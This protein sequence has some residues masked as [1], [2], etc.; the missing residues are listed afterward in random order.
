MPVDGAETVFV[1]LLVDP[2][3]VVLGAEPGGGAWVVPGQSLA[4]ILI[5]YHEV[6]FADWW[7]DLVARAAGQRHQSVAR[8]TQPDGRTSPVMVSLSSVSGGQA[9]LLTCLPPGSR[10]IA[11]LHAL[12]STSVA[13]SRLDLDGVLLTVREKVCALL[14]AECFYI[15]LYDREVGL[16]QLRE[17]VDDHQYLGGTSIVQS[18]QEGLVGWVLNNR[19]RLHVGD[20][21]RDPLPAPMVVHGSTPRALLLVP[22][23]AH[24]E[25][26]GALSVQSY[27]PDI[28]TEEDLWFLDAIAAQTA[29]AVHNAYLYDQTISRLAALASLQNTVLSLASTFDQEN[30]VA[31]VE[32]AVL[33]LLGPDEV[34]VYL[35]APLTGELCFAAG[36]TPQGRTGAREDPLLDSLVALIDEQGEPLLLADAQEG[37]AIVGDFDWPPAAL[38]G[39]PIRR[40]GQRC[41]VLLLLYREARCFRQDERHILSLLASQTAI[42]LENAR[43]H[44]D[45]VHRF[46]EVSA[47]Y[48]LAQ[49]VTG[50]LDG[51]DILQLVV[52]TMRDIF[53]CRACVLALLDEESQEIVI[54]AAAG[55]KEHWKA[56]ARFRVGE[57]VAGSVVATGRSIYVPD[58][59][60]DPN[61]LIFDPEVHSL[62]AVPVMFK[63]RVVGSLNLDSAVPN[64]FSPEH[65]RILTIAAAQVAAA[66][67]NARLY[68]AEL[69]RARKLAEAN[70]Q[71]EHYEK[72]R[73]ELIQNLAHELN[74]PLTYIKGYAGLLQAGEL[75]PVLPE[76]AEALSVV[77]EK[78]DV[79][80]QVVHDVVML[81]Q[82]SPDTLDLEP[83]EINVLARQALA[84][85]RL[86][87][88]AG[89]LRFELD[90]LPGECWVLG[91]R[92]RLNQV[93]DNLLSNAIKFTPEGG[94][95]ALRTRLQ[96]DG[97]EV[98]VAVADSGIGIPAE[99]LERI[100]ERF[101]QV[102]DPARRGVGGSGIGLTIV[103]RVIE[104]H[105]G[106][107]WVESEPGK[108][109][110]FTFALPVLEGYAV[111]GG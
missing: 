29:M 70:R 44:A 100:F 73:Q 49:Q 92:S 109:S 46:E 17:V 106:R 12:Q 71:L 80:E 74:T 83:L 36:R 104:A 101:Y 85:A 60:A 23:I 51:E 31:I 56:A 14:P 11:L 111:R 78:A 102:R 72:L 8:L 20:V 76:Q 34:R 79:L 107:I 58:V 48:D 57:G 94:V 33:S 96:A 69:E 99:H 18:P 32:Q 93:L 10:R 55:I 6:P 82:I 88:G 28:Y 16:I 66:L 47:L 110:V 62:I 40:A 38:A 37:P 53:Q 15:A 61:A 68:Q 13:L 97:R 67:E 30:V 108:G 50:Q 89:R 42:A 103:R 19:K 105:R 90:L 59:H 95:V 7:D 45:L 22:L 39:Y 3:G 77:A 87:H 64:A 2:S 41:G 1:A 91:N 24:G 4:T 81:E 52:H 21:Q 75:G 26:V 65:E 63:N 5:P 86:I 54:R 43:Y 9:F 27:Q 98:A 84:S 25:V 35:H